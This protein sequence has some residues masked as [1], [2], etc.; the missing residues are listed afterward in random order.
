MKNRVIKIKDLVLIF[1]ALLLINTGCVDLE[2]TPKDFTGPSNF[3]NSPT[4]IEAAFISSMSRLYGE[5]SVY[6]YGHG[7]FASDDQLYGGNLNFSDNQGGGL[8]SAHY[9]AIADLNPAILA[10]NVDK[11]A[12]SA[13]QEEKDQLMAQAKFLRAYNYFNLVRLFGD[14]PLIT[15]ET[16]V[17]TDEIL[18]TPIADVYAFIE[19]DLMYATQNLPE[20]WS[21]DTQGRPAKAAAKTLLAKVYVTMATA[22][23]NNASYFA[24]A[25]DMAADVM[26]DGTYSLVPD[27][28]E[29]FELENAYGP[30]IMWSFNAS[31]DDITTPPQIWLP[32]SMADGWGDF[33]SDKVWGESY[34]AQ[35]RKDAYLLLED[36]D[37]EPYTTFDGTTPYVKKFLYDTQENQERYRS[38]QNIPILRFADALLIFAEAENMANGGPTQAAVD[39]VNQII[40]RANDYVANPN[41]ALLTTSMSQAA[42][43]AAVIQQRNLELCFEYDRW[44][45]LVRKRILCQMTIPAYLPNCSDNDY[46]WPIPQTDLRLNPKLIQNPGYTTPPPAGG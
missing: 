22:P 25:R 16:N 23:L 4:Q 28:N 30:E 37:G 45:D 32:G 41:D 6:G 36:W 10:L 15:E 17:V 35:P 14:T 9:R 11:L 46:L 26:D 40:N 8:W 5:W 7:F 2:E 31:E 34:P 18:R 12:N 27:I 13:T 3:Y 24:K 38:V 19:S 33:K 29:V 21:D 20:T 1:G 43:D 44:F 39:A 42:F